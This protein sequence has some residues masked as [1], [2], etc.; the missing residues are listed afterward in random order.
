MDIRQYYRAMKEESFLGPNDQWYTELKKRLS[1]YVTVINN[2]QDFE[3][4]NLQ[5]LRGL[6][7]HSIKIWVR[8]RLVR[9]WNDYITTELLNNTLIKEL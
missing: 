5:V 6:S 9:G 7:L 4:I 1:Q 3:S 2:F 8:M